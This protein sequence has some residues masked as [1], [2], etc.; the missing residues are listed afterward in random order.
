MP[1]NTLLTQLGLSAKE[2]EIY[3]ILLKL[4]NIPAS[5]LLSLTKLKR[6]TVYSVLEELVK[7]S[8]VEK[9]ESSAIIK[10][11]CKHPYVLKEYIENQVLKIK[12]AE[13]VLDS[14]LPELISSY[15]TVQN[16]P[17]VKFYEGLEGIKK[18]Y[19]DIL[20]EGKD[21]LLI[22]AGF[23]AVYEK[24]IIPKVLTDF[25]KQRVKKNIKVTAIT[26]EQPQASSAKDVSQ[27]FTRQWVPLDFYSAPVEINI[28]G[29]K[30]ALLSYAK[31][32]VGLIIESPQISLALR[33][34][35]YLA[36]LGAKQADSETNKK[37]AE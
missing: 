9:D 29:D 13:S 37:S 15:N 17:G 26:P 34:I 4:G 5:K 33:Q 21:F 6:T 36:E 16:R 20:N 10:F 22:R 28:Y 11:R 27:L 23:E 7:K 24:E 8:I 30:V 31:E 12:T 18:I 35:F 2:A 19:D 32:I 1:T 25:I 3:Q 14:A